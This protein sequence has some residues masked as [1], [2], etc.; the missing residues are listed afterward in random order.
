MTSNRKQLLDGAF[1]QIKS[2]SLWGKMTGLLTVLVLMLQAYYDIRDDVQSA[3][4]EIGQTENGIQ[5]KGQLAEKETMAAILELQ[6][7]LQFIY[8]E[9]ILLRDRVEDLELENRRFQTR[10]ERY[11]DLSGIPPEEMPEK[12]LRSLARL[13]LPFL[14]DESETKSGVEER[15]EYVTLSVESPPAEPRSEDMPE[16]VDS[17]GKLTFNDYQKTW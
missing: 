1:K 14:S 7:K 17:D 13:L 12:D 8:T 15:S 4:E 5:R 16:H 3:K 11:R 2:P 9:S 6:D 10:L